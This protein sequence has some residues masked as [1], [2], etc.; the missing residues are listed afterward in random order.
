MATVI[1]V[2]FGASVISWARVCLPGRSDKLFVSEKDGKLRRDE[3]YGRKHLE[4][5]LRF[6]EHCIGVILLV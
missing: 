1:D 3:D 5:A 4:F 2:I 6:E